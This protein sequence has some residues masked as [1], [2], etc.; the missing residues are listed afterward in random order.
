MFALA[1]EL[2]PYLLGPYV[3]AT[4]AALFWMTVNYVRYNYDRNYIPLNNSNNDNDHIGG[5]VG[6]RDDDVNGQA[7]VEDGQ[8]K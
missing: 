4:V 7:C 1:L 2:Q 6:S 8:R 5:H 3:G